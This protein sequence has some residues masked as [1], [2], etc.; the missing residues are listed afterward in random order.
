ML[1]A[2]SQSSIHLDL[3]WQQTNSSYK[4]N[5]DRR[6]KR[7][8]KLVRYFHHIYQLPIQEAH[9]NPGENAIARPW[10]A[11]PAVRGL[12][13]WTSPPKLWLCIVP[14]TQSGL[15]KW[16]KIGECAF[17]NIRET[18][19]L[20]A[21]PRPS[22]TLCGVPA[23]AFICG[24]SLQLDAKVSRGEKR[25][26]KNE[27]I[28]I[29]VLTSHDDPI[30]TKKQKNAF[31]VSSGICGAPATVLSHG[32]PHWAADVSGLLQPSAT[33]HLKATAAMLRLLSLACG[34]TKSLLFANILCSIV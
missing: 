34:Y 12:L 31:S 8:K 1:P 22:G 26:S 17:W 32:A 23:G 18:T 6:S 11:A 27:T 3:D 33:Y 29:M 7:I 19:Q 2:F 4:R 20:F 16:G 13:S 24:D 28:L 14:A 5:S 15:V 30:Q 9:L 21:R 25:S 10:L